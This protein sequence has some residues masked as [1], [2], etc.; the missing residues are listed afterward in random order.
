MRFLRSKTISRIIFIF[1][2]FSMA[3]VLLI[4]SLIVLNRSV[5]PM[6]GKSRF[7]KVQSIDTMKYSRDLALQALK[8][9]Q[10]QNTINKQM[11]DIAATGA[12]HVA[13]GTP[14]DEKF[15]PILQKWVIA[16]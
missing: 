13:I 7:L 6:H 12:T 5:K 15:Y 1:A 10:F 16:A 2:F 8:D 9:P 3:S 11:S 14:Y 4:I